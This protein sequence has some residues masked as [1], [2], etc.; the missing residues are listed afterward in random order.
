MEKVLKDLYNGEIYPAEQYQLATPEYKAA[1]KKQLLLYEAFLE[2]LDKPLVREFEHIL[3]AQLDTLSLELS[4]MFID[5]FRLGAK[6][7]IE[8]LKDED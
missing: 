6:M 1:Q 3:D 4:A 8:V 2:K 5:G 7:M